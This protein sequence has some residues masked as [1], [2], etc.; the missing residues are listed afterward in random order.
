MSPLTVGAI[1]IVVLNNRVQ[2]DEM[3]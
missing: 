3:N 1:V 2:S